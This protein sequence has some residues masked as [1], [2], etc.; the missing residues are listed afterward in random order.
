MHGEDRREDR[1]L[2]ADPGEQTYHQ[3]CE[4]RPAAGAEQVECEADPDRTVAVGEAGRTAVEVERRQSYR[5]RGLA[6]WSR[7]ARATAAS[8]KREGG[9]QQMGGQRPARRRHS[10]GDES[11]QDAAAGAGRKDR[12]GLG[13]PAGRSTSAGL[14]VEGVVCEDGTAPRTYSSHE[15]RG[16][17][18]RRRSRHSAHPR[19][20]A[21]MHWRM[22]LLDLCGP[23]VMRLL[24]L[25]LCPRARLPAAPCSV[26]IPRHSGSG[27]SPLRGAARRCGA[28]CARRRAG[29]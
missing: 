3:A 4:E 24:T 23:S 20:S 1:K 22:A 27:V 26:Q 28:G 8:I 15:E 10:R 6:S 9:D 11:A 17:R 29:C 2:G 7:D 16:R 14:V 12:N 18:I 21:E 19:A 13:G 5:E 25:T